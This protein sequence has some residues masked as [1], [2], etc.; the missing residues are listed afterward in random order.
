V[1]D[2]YLEAPCGWSERYGAW[3]AYKDVRRIAQL[4]R[5][6]CDDERCMTAKITDEIPNKGLMAAVQI[7]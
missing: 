5:A 2:W 7:A 1:N 3:H 6:T 4:H